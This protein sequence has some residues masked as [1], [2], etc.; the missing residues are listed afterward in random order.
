MRATTAVLA[1]LLAAGASAGHLEVAVSNVTSNVA[2]CIDGEATCQLNLHIVHWISPTSR[3]ATQLSSAAMVTY[4]Y[5]DGTAGDA[6]PLHTRSEYTLHD[7]TN[8][9]R[10][11]LPHRHSAVTRRVVKAPNPDMTRFLLYRR[12][13]D[14]TPARRSRRGAS[15]SSSSPSSRRR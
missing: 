12:C 3:V 15:R 4:T 13:M 2:I 8:S 14:T 7:T 1:L 9:V 6:F 11:W 10:G 5:A